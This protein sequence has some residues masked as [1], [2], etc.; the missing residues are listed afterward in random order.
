MTQHLNKILESE[1]CG[2][3]FAFIGKK[4]VASTGFDRLFHGTTK[5]DL[6]A[7]RTSGLPARGE[8]LDL[9]QHAEQPAGMELSAFR[10][11]CEFMTMPG[12]LSKGAAGWAD[13][14][15]VIFEIR[16]YRGYDLTQ[17][18]ELSVET[19]MGTWRDMIVKEQEIAIPAEVPAR[20]I[21]AVALPKLGRGNRLLW[22]LHRIE[23]LA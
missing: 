18:T 17:L 3:A 8:N 2:Y 7:V 11:A 14:S 6:S 12:D 9:I 15:G 16:D 20:Y 10:G 21:P 5:F 13:E 1:I 19:P 22:N 23:E 4:K